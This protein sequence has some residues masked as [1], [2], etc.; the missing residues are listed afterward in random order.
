MRPNAQAARRGR[1][2][3]LQKQVTIMK[4]PFKGYVGTVTE[5]NEQMARVELHTKN[6]HISVSKEHLKELGSGQAGPSQTYGA[7]Q[8]YGG[9]YRTPSQTGGA[10]TPMHAGYSGGQTPMHGG[11][12]GSQTPMYGGGRTPLHDGSGGGGRTPAWQAQTP[13]WDPTRT[14]TWTAS[15][16]SSVPTPAS[17]HWDD[18]VSTPRNNPNTPGLDINPSSPY[19]GDAE[20]PSSS[21]SRLPPT[22]G[23][24]VYGG[25]NPET[26]SAGGSGNMVP[27]T[28]G[29][30]YGT[31]FTPGVYSSP[32]PATPY[33]SY[34]STPSS[35]AVDTWLSAGIVVRD[36]SGM[37]RGQQAVVREVYPD[38]Q[39]LLF[40]LDDKKV[41][42]C[43]G[44]N[45]DPVEPVEGDT[46][47]V[48]RG[49]NKGQDGTF[50]NQ[51]AADVIVQWADGNISM[52]KITDLCK[53]FSS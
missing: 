32:A 34:V 12:M 17:S 31:P 36:I 52:R 4:G 2:V 37:F 18:H 45:V 26:P 21:S 14:S 9:G 48:I 28:P 7:R 42:R 35:Q 29:S 27:A 3:L 53:V 13:T 8:D 51:D 15:T 39:I 6:K 10:Q 23:Y 38:G 47:R 11:Q 46:L 5:V 30:G 43:G 22:P 25:N 50:I 33:D 20:T 44:D 16:P 49:A 19:V 41:M 24:G 40:L 1:E